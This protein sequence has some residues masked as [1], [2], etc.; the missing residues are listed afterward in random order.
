MA[1]NP[2]TADAQALRLTLAREIQKLNPTAPSLRNAA[3]NTFSD[4][5]R[6]RDLIEQ[7]ARL[8]AAG[9]LLEQDVYTKAG[10]GLLENLIDNQPQCSLAATYRR[11][12]QLE[13]PDEWTVG[14]ALQWGAYNLNRLRRESLG[15]PEAA[16][17]LLKTWDA[18]TVGDGKF[19]LTATYKHRAAYSLEAVTS[20][21]VPVPGFTPINQTSSSELAA[22]LQWG[23][24][25]EQKVG[26]QKPRVDLLI[27][28]V[29]T[30]ND[31][32]RT[33]SR[34]VGTVTLTVP[35][36]DAISIPVSFTYANKPE[37][38]GQQSQALGAHLGVTYR[39]PGLSL[40]P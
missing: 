4:S 22:R 37:F 30:W 34:A 21:G 9:T 16:A 12:G 33:K 40:T 14:L 15:K 5:K 11:V 3:I 20:G 32:V 35:A 27:D 25:I 38:L 31:S 1:A 23:T 8:E 36:G 29:E 10:F 7:L 18:A 13:G 6:A 19:V 28:L 39:I 24:K 26:G 2:E 17:S